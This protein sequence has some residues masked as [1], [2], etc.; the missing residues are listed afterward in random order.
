[1]KFV[2]LHEEIDQAS[3][4]ITPAPGQTFIE[5]YEELETRVWGNK[6]YCNPR[7]VMFR[8]GRQWIRLDSENVTRAS[9]AIAEV[10]EVKPE[11]YAKIALRDAR[12]WAKRVG[13]VGWVLPRLGSEVV[14]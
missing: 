7:A 5:A 6:V 1:M 9:E 14:A 8:L 4:D 12:H 13:R 2:S 11:F 10:Q 3:F